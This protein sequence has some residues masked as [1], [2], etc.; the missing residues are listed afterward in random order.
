MKIEWVTQDSD[1]KCFEW[2]DGKYRIVFYIDRVSVIGKDYS[3]KVHKIVFTKH[4]FSMKIHR[5]LFPRVILA[6]D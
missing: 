1:D 5:M 3:G 2:D 4:E 6:N